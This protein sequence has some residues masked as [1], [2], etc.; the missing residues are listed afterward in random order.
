MSVE[1][2][3]S[4]MYMGQKVQSGSRMIFQGEYFDLDGGRHYKEMY[5]CTFKYVEDGKFYIEVDGKLY[6]HKKLNYNS[7]HYFVELN[8]KKIPNPVTEDDVKAGT[9]FLIFIMAI[10]SIFK[11]AIILWI[12]ELIFYFVWAN[13]KKH[14]Y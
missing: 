4:F 6:Y 7:I 13:S 10:T 5:P 11:G 2:R 3:H 8:G 9:I 12:F 1:R 14:P